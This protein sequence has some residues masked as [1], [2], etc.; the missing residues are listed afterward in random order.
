MKIFNVPK[1]K[2][3]FNGIENKIPEELS[4]FHWEEN[5][6]IVQV[7]L[8]EE[9]H[10]GSDAQKH[11]YVVEEQLNLIS[12]EENVNHIEQ[13]VSVKGANNKEIYFDVI[14]EDGSYYLIKFPS[15]EKVTN[16]EKL[17]EILKNSDDLLGD[18][19]VTRKGNKGVIINYDGTSCKN[20]YKKM[21][22]KGIN[23]QDN[24]IAILDFITDTSYNVRVMQLC[25]EGEIQK[26]CIS[27][28]GLTACVAINHQSE[29]SKIIVVDLE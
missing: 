21:F 14:D 19:W 17:E 24:Q 10:W 7:N 27:G 1:F 2:C 3:F 9:Y 18:Y 5:K 16:K 25:D 11:F 12:F 22:L 29:D 20:Q 4:V 23:L 8:G 26:V 28:D 13:L 15:M 6:F